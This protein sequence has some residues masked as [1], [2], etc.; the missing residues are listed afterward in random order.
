MFL[1]ASHPGSKYNANKLKMHFLSFVETASQ[2]NAGFKCAD[3]NAC[4]KN[5]K[6]KTAI[7]L[8]KIYKANKRKVQQDTVSLL[9]EILMP[10]E[11]S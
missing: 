7:P 6:R 10:S 2:H 11:S 1:N 3:M 5:E 9:V 4:H 8:T